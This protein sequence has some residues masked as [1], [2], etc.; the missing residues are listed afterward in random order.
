MNNVKTILSALLMLASSLYSVAQEAPT[1]YVKA[2][3]VTTADGTQ[4]K[5]AL[6]EKPQL[7]IEKPYLVVKTNGIKTDFELEQMVSL[8]YIDV[9]V[10]PGDAYEDGLINTTDITTMVNYLMGKRASEFS[11]G[12]ADANDDE[13]LNVADIVKTGN[14]IHTGDFLAT[15]RGEN[16]DKPQT[17]AQRA[18][19]SN[20]GQSQYALYN[21]RNDANFNAWLN[22]DID[23]ITYSKTDT[24]GVVH[25]DLV[26]QEVWTPD[27]TYRIPI[28][29]I[30]SIGF[31]VPEPVF[32]N[33][34]F[35]IT[36]DYCPYVKDTDD[37]SISFNS[38]IPSSMLPDIGQVI[39]SDVYGKVPFE[40]GFAGR[41]QNI[42]NESNLVKIEC[43]V[44]T[45]DDIY[46]QIICVGR[47]ITY[48]SDETTARGRHNAPDWLSINKD[49]TLG[50]EL[51]PI[52]IKLKDPDVESSDMSI[53]LDITPSMSIDYT[54]VYN[55][56]GMNNHFK[57][58]AK[59]QLDFDLD[60]KYKSKLW[61][62]KILKMEDSYIP[63]KTTIPGLTL[64][65]KWGGFFDYEGNLSIDGKLSYKAVM[66]VGYD[67]A[68]EDYYG[69]VFNNDGSGWGEP[70]VS[71][72][73]NG[74]IFFGPAFQLVACLVSE[75][76]LPSFTIT[77]KPG[78][79]LSGKF[80][81]NDDMFTG[82]SISVYD[83]LKNTK[84]SCSGE[85]SIEG[86]AKVFSEEFTL[87]STEWKPDWLKQ[88]FYLFP[89][90][91]EAA[92][93][94]MS[95]INGTDYSASSLYSEVSRNLFLPCK[96]G[97]AVYDL[98]GKKVREQFNEERYW[99]EKD[100]SKSLPVDRV[101]RVGVNMGGLPSNNI[102][103][104]CPVVK[105]IMPMFEVEQASPTTLFQIPLSLELEQNNLNIGIGQIKEIPVYRGWGDYQIINGDVKV[106]KAS[107]FPDSFTP[108]GGAGG[109][110]G[111]SWVSGDSSSSST[112][113]KPQL[114]IEG[115]GVGKTTIQVKDMRSNE[116]ASINVVVTDE[117]TPSLE[118][119]STLLT[120]VVGKQGTVT[121]SSGSG[122]YKA[123]SSDADVATVKINNGSIEV[124]AVNSGTATITVT[125]METLLT[126]SIKVTVT[127]ESIDIPAEAVDLGLPSGTKW[128][129][130]NVGA[131][132]PEEYGDYFAWGETTP[133]S[134][135]QYTY[136]S[137][138]YCNGW[139]DYSK[140]MTNKLTK[141]C[142]DPD[143]GNNGF[144]DGNKI[145]EARDD[146]A[147]D[148]WGDGW[149]IPTI[150]QYKELLSYT[151]SEIAT[152]N[153]VNGVR[154]TSKINNNSVFFPVAGYRYDGGLHDAGTRSAYWAS[155]ITESY[156]SR[157]HSLHIDWKWTSVAGW[158]ESERCFGLPVR[159]VINTP[160]AQAAI[161]VEPQS[162]DFGT[163]TKGSS[164]TDYFIVYN[165]GR[166]NLVFHLDYSTLDGVFNVLEGGEETV[167]K[168]G[169]SK[170]YTVTCT[171]PKDYEYYGGGVAIYVRS[172][173]SNDE[174]VMVSVGMNV[175]HEENQDVPAE[176]V[177]LGLPSGTLWASC[178]VGAT[179]PEEMGGYYAWG[180]TEEKTDYTKDTYLY[181]SN[182][183]NGGD[184]I[185]EDICGT[186]YDV[187]HVKWRQGWQ[188]PD[189][190]QIKEL[191]ENCSHEV[192]EQNNVKG[193]KFT[194]TNGNSI[195]MPI[196]GLYIG[197]KVYGKDDYCVYWTGIPP[198]PLG[199]AVYYLYVD[200]KGE[201]HWD[202]LPENRYYRY[203]GMPIRPVINI[204]LA[205][206]GTDTIGGGD[207]V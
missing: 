103:K 125:D 55:V 197:N 16:Q 102:Y 78:C 88:D 25:K 52:K 69:F 172:N 181:W 142:T 182:Q 184:D 154:F 8:K 47:T 93:L 85:L 64:K 21:Y 169:E 177:D 144:A 170:K 159:P 147:T 195:F 83:A 133:Q 38:S 95:E 3:L 77:A 89:N 206:P 134:N 28:E 27:S 151:T 58:I 101:N 112:E 143:F 128:A 108:S 115:I 60:F 204:K 192:V 110:G 24:L 11:F 201:T 141:Y 1:K 148:N 48:S 166:D 34:V 113:N 65:L 46:D 75:K 196:T 12:N 74:Y 66:N 123:E 100:W 107:F 22:I 39:I 149:C 81:I 37:L 97:M 18:P 57:I 122:K 183:F 49:G 23:S 127:E 136:E 50:V 137:Y 4:T 51:L 153:G 26:V 98:E 29:A 31:R 180:E 120:L 76:W 194:G 157:A 186:N 94:D 188:M 179:K 140:Y 92:L 155:D 205:G 150:S 96:I 163:M 59:P 168:P 43:G 203:Y 79:K 173:A 126:A 164:K 160:P 119:S 156:P 199:T 111:T 124:T 5:F 91:T 7:T 86:K 56:K 2:L 138:K 105:S 135:S 165:T 10:V 42:V 118:L 19:S 189:L 174:S 61:G 187:A 54:F 20:S 63:I 117:E 130:Y 67:S 129:S 53:G 109:G 202:Y 30:D 41:V 36:E 32:K 82:E 121:V 62:D 190:D 171:I 104:V 132:R 71:V 80:E 9:P 162:I 99:F 191:L 116:I 70:D 44:V 131:S 87:P 68:K 17:A 185:G 13:A 33:D 106:A 167:L 193:M 145:L 72:S 207:E 158:G 161:K 114:F 176:A 6:K 45:L 178:N 14:I 15:S 40:S 139:F 73:L 200:G 175:T 198:T 35:H 152:Q 90:F 146:A 84:V